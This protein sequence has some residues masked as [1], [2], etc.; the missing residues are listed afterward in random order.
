MRAGARSSD[1]AIVT[2][3]SRTLAEKVERREKLQLRIRGAP[4][5]CPGIESHDTLVLRHAD[6]RA[7]AIDSPA[8]FQS[9]RVY[10][11]D[12]PIVTPPGA[13]TTAIVTPSITRVG[14]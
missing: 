8:E 2:C 4:R 14:G 9:R 11:P 5:T 13:R 1:A 3:L 7:R 12:N 6:V 10:G